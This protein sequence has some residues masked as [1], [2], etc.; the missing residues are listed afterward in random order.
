VAASTPER[1]PVSDLAQAVT[2]DDRWVRRGATW[3]LAEVAQ[4]DPARARPVVERAIDLLP[5]GD[6]LVRENAV[7]TVAGASKYP[8]K[9]EPAIVSLAELRDADDGLVRR[10]ATEALRH[11]VDALSKLTLSGDSLVISVSDPRLADLL[12]AEPNVV[13]VGETGGRRA[14][15]YR[16]DVVGR[17][18]HAGDRRNGA[19]PASFGRAVERWSTIDDHDHVLTVRAHGDSPVP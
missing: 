1:V 12:P 19:L 13:Q 8:R 15:S 2:D 18:R 10:Y 4:T 14:D 3:A 7:I 16:P 11:V 6:P 17:C 9:A 5:D